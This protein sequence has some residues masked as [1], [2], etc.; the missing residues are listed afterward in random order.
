[1]AQQR[2]AGIQEMVQPPLLTSALSLPVHSVLPCSLGV[3]D[4]STVR[5]AGYSDYPVS[6]MRKQRARDGKRMG[7]ENLLS[8]APRTSSCLLYYFPTSKSNRSG[9]L[10]TAGLQP[11][12]F[13]DFSKSLHISEPG[14]FT[15]L[16][17]IVFTWKIK[18]TTVPKK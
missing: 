17:L 1:M 13:S 6:Q 10:G 8:H 12:I 2:W 3:L 15:S 14:H 16:S 7:D 9:C 11:P 4:I 5:M 18:T